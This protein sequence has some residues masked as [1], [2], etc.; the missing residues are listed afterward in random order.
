[1]NYASSRVTCHPPLVRPALLPLAWVYRLAVRVRT[2][3]YAWGWL[4]SRRLPCRVVSIGNLT[5]GGT[6]KTPL[7][8][9]LTEW[10]M[11]RGKRVGVLS[12]G[13]RRRAPSEQVLVSDGTQVLAG[14]GEAGD[15]PYLI[16]RRCPGAVVAV[17]VD[18]YRLGR[19][20]LDRF[21]LDV[22]LLDDGF[23]HLALHRDVDVV[24][25][26][27]SE[28]EG[29]LALLPAG[30]LREPIS[31]LARAH[32]VLLTR[33]E[34]ES[35]VS[36]VMAMLEKATLRRRPWLM[37]FATEGLMNVATGEQIDPG[38]VKGR[39][40]LA[41]SGIGNPSSFRRLLEGLGALVLD[42]L[43]F[44]DHHAYTRAD[45]EHIRAQAKRSGVEY[46]LTTEKDAVKLAGFLPE[47]DP[48]WAIRLKT[49]MRER[50]AELEQLIWGE[51]A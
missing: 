21:P 40:A 31:A 33:A 19:W 51:R 44:P 18:R 34:K 47:A 22:L 42:E 50:K 29:L 32:A 12:R 36:A 5:A 30:R 9:A 48:F 2:A 1:M 25:V 49:E 46:I 4:R 15:E 6:G 41:V 35:E 39:P 14:P 24:L 16:A 26:D 27:A 23:Q 10:L 8:I 37:Q 7:V 28:P 11:A 3:L 38:H 13:Y 43:R 45:V 20:V 17:G